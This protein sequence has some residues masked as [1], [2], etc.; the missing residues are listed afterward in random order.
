MSDSLGIQRYIQKKYNLESEY[1]A[2]GAHVFTN[3]E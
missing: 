2:Y 1:I 3:P